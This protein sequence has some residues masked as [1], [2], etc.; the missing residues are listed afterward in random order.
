MMR[1]YVC[2]GLL[3]PKS[4]LNVGS[5]LRICGNFG[6][7]MLAISGKRFAKYKP[8]CTDTMAQYRHMPLLEAEDMQALLP[9]DCVPIA[10]E[11]GGDNICTFTHPERAFYIFGPED[12]GVSKAVQRWCARTITVPTDRCMNLAV[13]IGV[14]LYDRLLKNG[15]G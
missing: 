6:V 5:A 1:G 14:V 7:Q 11:L 3:N 8:Q 13:S 12:G 2:V 15:G 9:Y 10:V 4:P